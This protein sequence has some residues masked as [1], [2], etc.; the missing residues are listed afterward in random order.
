MN[1]LILFK[2]QWGQET[3]AEATIALI[4]WLNIVCIA[5]MILIVNLDELQH[6]YT[7]GVYSRI[8]F[9]LVPFILTA[10]CGFAGGVVFGI[11]G[12]IITKLLRMDRRYEDFKYNLGWISIP[13]IFGMLSG[14]IIPLILMIST[15]KTKE[16]MAAIILI[17]SVLLLGMRF[18]FKREVELRRGMIECIGVILSTVSVIFLMNFIDYIDLKPGQ[19]SYF[20]VQRINTLRLQIWSFGLIGGSLIGWAT[21]LPLHFRMP[22]PDRKKISLIIPGLLSILWSIERMILGIA[23]ETSTFALM[24]SPNNYSYSVV[25]AAIVMII[26]VVLG[27]FLITRGLT[28]IVCSILERKKIASETSKI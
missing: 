21:A 18:R 12:M 2:S 24:P 4:S 23:S 8:E 17:I 10:F 22:I 28:N 13:S 9:D 15:T 1:W 19:S 27:G 6:H 14:I 11:M 20:D 26:T 3:K 16:E 7:Y 5:I 25:Y